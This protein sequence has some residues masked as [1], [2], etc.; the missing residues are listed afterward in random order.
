MNNSLEKVLENA[1]GGLIGSLL[2]SMATPENLA[3]ISEQFLQTNGSQHCKH[4]AD[5]AIAA[6][7][8][9]KNGA[10]SKDQAL[11]ICAIALEDS[12]KTIDVDA[13]RTLER[14]FN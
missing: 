4:T 3:H 11:R 5:P 13:I 6:L 2:Q 7:K 1:L 9:Y 12:G 10:I 14:L 8:A